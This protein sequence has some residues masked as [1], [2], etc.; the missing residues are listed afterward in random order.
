MRVTGKRRFS[1]L[2]LAIRLAQ[3]G[4]AGVAPVGQSI[5]AEFG[6]GIEKNVL[7]IQSHDCN[8]GVEL[9]HA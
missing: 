3:P 7:A 4:H 6:A 5:R 9:R 8:L 2:R 1:R